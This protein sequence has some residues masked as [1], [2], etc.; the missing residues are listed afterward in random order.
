[1]SSSWLI[2]CIRRHFPSGTAPDP[3]G[4][5]EALARRLADLRGLKRIRHQLASLVSVAVGGTAAGLGGPLAIAQAAAGWD[6]DVL[7]VHGCRVSPRTGL[8]VAPS[9]STLGRL[10]EMIDPDGFE[11]ALADRVRRGGRAR[12]RGPGRV[13]RAP[14]GRTA[15]QG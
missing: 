10:P 5:R 14:R 6:Q 7:A 12:S 4:F 2:E 11:A 3:V 1:M 15:H 8:R 9:A 13:R